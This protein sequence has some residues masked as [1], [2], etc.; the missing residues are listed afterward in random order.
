MSEKQKFSRWDNE[1]ALTLKLL[2]AFPR[3]KRPEAHPAA[4]AR[5]T[6]LD[7]RLRRRR[8]AQ[9]VQGEM[10]FPRRTSAMPHTWQGMVGEVEKALKTIS[11]KV[12]RWTTRSSIR[13]SSS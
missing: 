1:S 4:A 3:T 5:K 6:S 7:L 13:R 8:R 10:K 2:K 11:D 9:A 12:R